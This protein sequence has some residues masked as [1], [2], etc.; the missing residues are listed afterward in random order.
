MNKLEALGLECVCEQMFTNDFNKPELSMNLTGRLKLSWDGNYVV[1]D[2]N[3][4]GATYIN[5][6]GDMGDLLIACEAIKKV[7]DDPDN[8]VKLRALL[9]S[10]D[11]QMGLRDF[12]YCAFA[13]YKKG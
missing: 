2:V 10:Y 4:G 6:V 12:A 5:Y 3:T 13:D 7:V 11:N 9:W 8:N 1:F